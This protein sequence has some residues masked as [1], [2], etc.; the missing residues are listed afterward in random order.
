[1][2]HTDIASR[3]R[4]RAR[5]LRHNTTDAE[6]ALWRELRR[7]KALGFHFRRQTPVGPYVADFACL[8]KRLVVEIDGGQHGSGARKKLDEIRTRWLDS[9]GFRVVRFWNH[10][11]LADPR[12]VAGALLNELEAER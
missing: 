7:M 2:P 8:S 9:Q 5:S 11:V 6:M 4:R 3:T 10:D 1:M 12:T